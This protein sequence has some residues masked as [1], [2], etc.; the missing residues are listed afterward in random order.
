V[1][2]DSR[3]IADPEIE[4]GRDIKRQMGMATPL[5]NRIVQQ[6]TKQILENFKGHGKPH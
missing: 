3:D 4:L 6:T 1:Q 2:I 5:V